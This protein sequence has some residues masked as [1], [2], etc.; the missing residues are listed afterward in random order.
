MTARERLTGIAGLIVFFGL[1]AGCNALTSTRLPD[2]EPGR[3]YCEQVGGRYVPAPAHGLPKCMSPAGTE[4]T[5]GPGNPD[6]RDLDP[7]H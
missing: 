2:E 3:A 4:I 6:N 7:L 1:V 5:Y